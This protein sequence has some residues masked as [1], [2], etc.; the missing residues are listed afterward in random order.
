V[1]GVLRDEH[2][3]RLGR[4]LEANVQLKVENLLNVKFKEGVDAMRRF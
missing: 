3:I 1:P 2:S 4:E